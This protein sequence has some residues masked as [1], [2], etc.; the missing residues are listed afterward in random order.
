MFCPMRKF[1][2]RFLIFCGFTKALK[3]SALWPSCLQYQSR[4]LW[5][6]VQILVCYRYQLFLIDSDS[7]IVSYFAT[8]NNNALPDVKIFT[9]IFDFLWFHKSFERVGTL[10][11]LLAIAE[12]YG[13]GFK[14]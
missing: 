10:A 5:L 2:Q 3:E 4:K 14:S 11:F 12:Q 1:L 6:R 13:Y 7:I 8:K 9:K